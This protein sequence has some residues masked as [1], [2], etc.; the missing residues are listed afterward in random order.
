[1]RVCVCVSAVIITDYSLHIHK[2]S[3]DRLHSS[4]NNGTNVHL[5]QFRSSFNDIS[6]KN[7]P[8]KKNNPI[9][10]SSCEELLPFVSFLDTLMSI[11]V[12]FLKD[13]DLDCQFGK[14]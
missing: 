8:F 3:T 11:A 7:A 4:G 9:T 5:Q 14:L 6:L 1:M 2:L 10:S 13:V 12:L